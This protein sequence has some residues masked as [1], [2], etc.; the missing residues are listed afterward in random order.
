MDQA[1]Y[2]GTI[3]FTTDS[4]TLGES[5]D[6]ALWSLYA[7]ERKL[8][9]QSELRQEYIKFMDE[10]MKLGHMQEVIDIPQ[11]HYYLPHHWVVKLDSTSTKVRVIFHASAKTT[12]NVA[13]NGWPT[14]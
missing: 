10:Y 13:P 14:I 9:R 8:T 5:K 7:L 4:G 2:R 1:N 3:P 11:P 6:M 12:F